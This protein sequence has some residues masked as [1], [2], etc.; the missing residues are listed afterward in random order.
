M[1]ERILAHR[2]PPSRS[3]GSQVHDPNAEFLY[4]S[5]PEGYQGMSAARAVE[6]GLIR[7]CLMEKVPLLSTHDMNTSST[8]TRL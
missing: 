4:V 6:A 5:I 1:R 8:P 3:N 7:E 2:K